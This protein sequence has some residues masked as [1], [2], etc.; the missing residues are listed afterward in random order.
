MR[1]RPLDIGVE[2]ISELQVADDIHL[3]KEYGLGQP[4]L[5]GYRPLD[6]ILRRPSLDERLSSLLQPT[7]LDPELLQPST[8][9]E[10]RV[11]ARGLFAR[12]AKKESGGM[13]ALFESAAAV[14]D[15]GVELDD[16]VRRALA[17]LLRG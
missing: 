13:R 6:E 2:S 16:E 12:R 11:G 3:P 9:T 10:A 7:A 14:L 4:F 1:I 8:L 15:E 5:P 17:M